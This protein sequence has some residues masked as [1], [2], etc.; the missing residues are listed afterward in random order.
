MNIA[1]VHDWIVT[2]GGAE[3]V[4]EQLHRLWPTAPIYTLFYRQSV[5]QKLLP[6]ATIIASDLQKIPFVHR[7]YPFLAPLMPST[8]EAIDVS[9]YDTVISSSAIFSKGIIVRPD[10]RHICYCYSPTRMLWDRSEA[11]ERNDPLSRL[12]RHF[13]RS[14]D[15]AAG[16]RPDQLLAVSQ[17]TASRIKKYYRRSSIVIPP[18]TRMP[19]P[20]S[21]EGAPRGEF[22]LIVARMVP[23]K[24]L[25]LVLDAFA[26]LRYQLVIVGDGPLRSR[27]ARRAGPN[28]TFTGWVSDEALDAL[29]A[30]CRAVIVPNEEDW[31]LTAIEAMLRGKPV[32][33]LRRGGATETILEGLTGEFFDDPI[34]EALADG[35]KRIR[36][37]ITT[38]D[39]VAI[40]AHASQYGE[41]Q[42]R[43]R[44]QAIV[45]APL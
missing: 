39:P 41:E 36:S 4:L 8:I 13:L 42:F 16:Q 15:Y 25:D 30:T 3:R 37:A 20:L 31:G 44:M 26:K 21:T 33:A 28:I 12:Y 23:H 19:G 6:Q 18:P 35:M 1:L 10:T 34:P 43:Q 29:Y 5:V 14:W 32:L 2:I 9:R 17:T 7:L 11:Y 22:Y 24:A 40:A 45:Q 27:L 38:Y